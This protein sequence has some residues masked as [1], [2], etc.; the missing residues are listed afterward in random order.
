MPH[1]IEHA[2]PLDATQSLRI[3][4]LE[5][6]PDDVELCKR[7]LKRAFREVHCDAVASREAFST[8]LTGNT[9]DVI[10]AD[11]ALGLWT[12]MEAFQ[13]VRDSGRDIP[14]ILVTGA[15][16]DERAIDCIKTGIADYVLKDHPDRLPIA[17]SRA[18]KDRSLMEKR[19]QAEY[20][21]QQSE[22]QLRMLVESIPAATFVEQGT[23]CC[24]SNRAAEQITGYS[25]EELLNMTFWDLILPDSRKALI[26]LTNPHTESLPAYRYEID[27]LTKQ[28]TTRCLD[29][30]VAMFQ[31]DGG[32]AAL[33]TAFDIS[34]RNERETIERKR[35]E[36]QVRHSHKMEVLGRLCGGVAHDFNNL[37]GVMIG[38]AEHLQM[39]MERGNPLRAGADEIL[40][41]A[42]RAAC[43]TRQLLAF[44][45]PETLDRRPQDLN[46]VIS[47]IKN[48]LRRLIGDDIEL[49]TI[50]DPAPMTVHADKGQMEQI[51]MNLAANARDA[52]PEGGKL[53]IKT[54]STV[55]DEATIR[56][57]P[58]PIPFGPYICFSVT[59]TGFGMDAETKARAFDPFFSTK[60][61]GKGTGLGLATVY[62]V[63]KQ[64]NGHI[65][66]LTAPGAG[67]TFKI[68]LPQF[69]E[70]VQKPA[71]EPKDATLP[72]RHETVLL[73]EDDSS[74]RTAVRNTLQLAG[75]A[76]LEAKDGI[77]ALIVANKY[78][79]AI[80]LLIT[81]LV[82]PGLSGW[83]LAHELKEDRPSI[84]IV[85]M[86]GYPEQNLETQFPVAGSAF[87]AKP[88]TREALTRK[89]HETLS[90]SVPV[91]VA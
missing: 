8:L 35:L 50:L 76:V 19:R 75:Y 9:Y 74:L 72:D 88:F 38:Y 57:S 30:T 61:K 32:L 41:A 2:G 79:S 31:N 16:G 36:D 67:T 78:P 90:T 12:G 65:E 84:R 6:N 39:E 17:I 86:S 42:N 82:M 48:L 10:L 47:E 66:V 7:L 54:S 22:S 27:I 53:V 83:A 89:I 46:R 77:S 80:D 26:G 11:Y 40:G 1:E 64:S 52:M 49:S 14:F 69:Q 25:R 56:T 23:R 24:Y 5:D 73:V 71:P 3:L 21:L 44:S 15:L 28:G 58:Y 81:D 33:I 37:L 55:V 51:L 45:R 63:V 20:A 68:F 60:E 59:D 91:K 62:D 85:Y 43:L 87:L 13:L 70:A 4:L 29:V 18:I 34:E